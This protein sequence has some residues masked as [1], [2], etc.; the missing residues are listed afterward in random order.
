MRTG[1]RAQHV[2]PMSDDP[3]VDALA[4][5]LDDEQVKSDLADRLQWAGDAS[6][7]HMIPRI[8]VFPRMAEEVQVII[9]VAAH[10]NLPVCFRAGG[11]SLS[12][13][14]VT[15]GILIV[16]SRFMRRIRVK[17]DGAE[18]ACGPGAVGSWVNAA[19]AKYQKRIGPDPAS[20]QAA[21]IGG[22]VA[23]N[24]SGMC[25][26]IHENS[27]QTVTNLDLVLA[28]GYR[29]QTGTE[30]D[31]KQLE[32]EQPEIY[33]GLIAIR[34]RVRANEQL[35]AQIKKA[36]STKN[37]VGYS[38]NA[39]LD[40]DEPA[41]I[42]QKL[43]VGSEGTLAFI[44]EATFRT[45]DLPSHRSTA[46]L[47]FKT[48]EDA[49]DAVDALAQ[50][51]AAAVELLDALSL[52]R[53]EE[54]LPEAL[55]AGD[56]TAAL[57]VEYQEQEEA[58]L[59][60]RVEEAEQLCAVLALVSPAKF[61]GDPHVQAQ[62]W[63]V[64]KGLF[65][66]V[67]AV[68][69]AKTAVVI[70]DITFPVDQ[71]AQGVRALRKIFE[72]Y[73]YN[74]GVIFGHAKDGNLHFTL[75]P[76]FSDEQEVDRYK[77]F[78]DALAECVLSFG[79]HLKAE[80]GTGRNMAPFVEAQWGVEAVNIMYAVKDLLDPNELLNPGVLLTDDK[81]AHIK[82]LKIMPQVNE[83]VDRCIECGFCEPVCPS[84][85]AT[86][87]PR[88]RISLLRHAAQG[89]EQEHAVEE[90]WQHKGLDTCAADGMCATAC[91]V[92]INT[93]DLVK[94][95]RTQKRGGFKKWL[96]KR[97]ANNFSLTCWSAKQGV[98]VLRWVGLKRLP[99][100]QVYLPKAAPAFP[101]KWT[102]DG[103]RRTLVY[104]P[105]CLS[106]SFHSH[107]L[108]APQALQKIADAANIELIIPPKVGSLCC[109]QPFASKGFPDIA[110]QMQLRI[111]EQLAAIKQE[112]E[113][114]LIIDTSTCA[115]QL[116][117]MK[118]ALPDWEIVHPAA[119]L[120][121]IFIPVLREKDVLKEASLDV[122]LHPTCSE[123]KHNWMSE[124]SASANSVADAI[125]PADGGC[126]GMAGDR[127]WLEPSL[128]AAATAREAAEVMAITEQKTIQKSACTNMACGLALE[129]GTGNAYEHLWSLVAEQ[130]KES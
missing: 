23:N 62:L 102:Q 33:E 49:G 50:S 82:H 24:A 3:V 105:S 27:Y 11:T 118:K 88:Q 94:F 41:A 6:I 25:C 54:K 61:T 83:I 103:A 75:T 100:R 90:I 121:D 123:R 71:L 122:I 104:M 69:K 52:R 80:H 17:N 53:V 114:V 5:F 13:Q 89:P 99:K 55:P 109:G 14:S 22:I 9:G 78:M 63:S 31:N 35:S 34:D 67:G 7:Y 37:T 127:G 74:D 26:G 84:R 130:I 19:L 58:K 10:F 8:V 119:A 18:V 20:I 87:S 120:T 117:S 39:F 85:D 108:S 126:C 46:L 44:N 107:G 48:V 57:L 36:F 112:H 28:N 91:P 4:Q 76:D 12:G 73:D 129:A 42:L 81:Q 70:E 106:R 124:L 98:R 40:A 101:K 43:V 2:R 125:V 51:G 1:G 97:A 66:S 110:D 116:E 128:T 21:E 92:D 47:L 72:E 111:Q 29:L 86:L 93:G 79:G 45:I 16:V 77:R 30:Q 64:R 113:K 15:R 60:K 96:A 38:L 115:S 68:R 59:L 56:E 32:E 95:Q 65:P